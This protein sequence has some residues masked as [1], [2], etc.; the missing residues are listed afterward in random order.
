[1]W[2]SHYFAYDTATITEQ[3]RCTLSLWARLIFEQARSIWIFLWDWSWNNIPLITEECI[4]FNGSQSQVK[5]RRTAQ[6]KK[7]SLQR[8][9]DWF[10]YNLDTYSKVSWKWFAWDLVSQ[11]CIPNPLHKEYVDWTYESCCFPRKPESTSYWFEA[12]SSYW[13]WRYWNCVKTNYYPYDIAVTAF[14]IYAQHVLWKQNCKIK[15]DWRKKDRVEWY[16]LC[17]KATNAWDDFYL[18]H[19]EIYALIALIKK[20]MKRDIYVETFL[21][22]SDIDELPYVAKHHLH[23]T[24]LYTTTKEVIETPYWETYFAYSNLDQKNSPTKIVAVLPPSLEK[25]ASSNYWK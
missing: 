4:S 6:G 11:A 16:M 17:K 12:W 14:L 25:H 5:W 15:S 13:P 3:K 24:C 1:M 2:Y 21:K 8:P 19:E 18:E 20:R 10:N 22:H 9:D 23:T 7:N